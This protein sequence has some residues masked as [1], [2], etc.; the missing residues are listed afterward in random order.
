MASRFRLFRHALEHLPLALFVLALAIGLIAYGIA[1]ERYGLFPKSII[2]DGVKTAQVTAGNLRGQDIGEFRHFSSGWSDTLLADIPA[3]RI[4]AHYNGGGGSTDALLI[5][6]GR[7]QFLDL[8]PPPGCL[9]VA[10]APS[11]EIVHAWP[12]RPTAIFAANVVDENDYP[13]ELNGFSAERDLYPFQV[14]Q[15]PNGDLL[16]SFLR[17]RTFPTG[18]GVA[19]IDGDG[20]PRWFRGDYSHH[21]PRLD[22]DIAFVPSHTIGDDTLA[23]PYGD[24]VFT[25]RCNGRISRDALNVLDGDGNLLRQIPV[26]DIL[27][28]SSWSSVLIEHPHGP[29]PAH[30]GNAC[31]PLHLNSVDIVG[32]DADGSAGIMPGDIVLS[33][34]D[35]SAFAILDRGTY[36]IKRLV[37]GTFFRQH[38]VTHLSG[39]IFLM[40]D[41]MGGERIGVSSRLLMVDPATG[42]ERTIFPTPRTEDAL[43]KSS[44]IQGGIDISRNQQRAIA[45]FARRG[46]AVE[47]RLADGEVLTVYRSLHDVSTLDQF[48]DERLSRAA[49]FSLFDVRY[50]H[51]RGAAAN[52]GR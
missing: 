36:R 34:R 23:V 13:Y 26:F 43:R 39:S 5:L 1:I 32:A 15:Y 29:N 52:D 10:I 22:G 17:Q 45:I 19:R 6:G 3:Q 31:D 33:F 14:E 21:R 28:A 25:W 42:S 7:H 9:A 35:I 24:D 18:G 2:D 41:N 16:V 12:F 11:G 38:D 49:S 50:L 27:L 48:L 30:Y 4:T 46:M 37:R 8:C 47:V 44:R 20:Y 51:P 40:L